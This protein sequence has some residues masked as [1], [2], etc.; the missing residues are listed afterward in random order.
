MWKVSLWV[1][2][3]SRPTNGLESMAPEVSKYPAA[4]NSQP[5]K[6]PAGKADMMPTDTVPVE[7]EAAPA[8]G[9]TA[10]ESLDRGKKP[11]PAQEARPPVTLA[12][13]CFIY[14]ER[15][16]QNGEGIGGMFRR[17]EWLLVLSQKY[18]CAYVCN[19][20][21]WE[22]GGHSTG[23]VG[24]L[25][26]CSRDGIVGNSTLIASTSVL[27]SQGA[28]VET[29]S[30]HFDKSGPHLVRIK[31]GQ[32]MFRGSAYSMS[33]KPD[34]RR[35]RP[36]VYKL[37]CPQVQTV[38]H[39]MSYQWLQAQYSAVRLQ[40][41]RKTDWGSA[42]YRIALQLRRGDRPEACPLF[43]YLNALR[44]VFAAMPQISLQNSKILLIG[45]VNP[46][47]NEFEC[48]SEIQNLQFLASRRLVGRGSSGLKALKRDLDYIATSNILILGGGGSFP[49]FAA[50]LQAFGSTSIQ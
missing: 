42:T 2:E 47:S 14:S 35:K 16:C 3:A 37:S 18:G 30:L 31:S 23:N 26:G 46:K 32:P 9:K 34:P 10:Q 45:E 7:P 6:M 25:F 22:T 50:T 20:K 27:K 4:S 21:D 33:P 36:A 24:M 49:S 28:T 17:M 40:D 38:T 5:A 39:Q 13:P 44:Y 15:P 41:G 19:P 11:K 43:L 1:H 8:L 12:P 29:A 48:L